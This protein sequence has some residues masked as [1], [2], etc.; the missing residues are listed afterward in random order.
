MTHDEL[1]TAAKHLRDRIRDGYNYLITDY[2]S[3]IKSA[4]T[5]EFISFTHF[6]EQ[7][8]LKERMAEYVKNKLSQ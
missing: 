5:G 4:K 1:L 8:N 2:G 7:G 3:K 6:I